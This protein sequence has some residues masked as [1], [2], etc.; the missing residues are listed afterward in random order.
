MRRLLRGEAYE[1]PVRCLIPRGVEG[2]LAVGQCIGGSHEAYSS[3]RVMPT[4]IATGQA[5]GVCAAL[6]AVASKLRMT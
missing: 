1:T 2:V 6:A 3:C 5:A 4:S